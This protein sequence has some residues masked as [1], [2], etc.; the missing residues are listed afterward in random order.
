MAIAINGS[1]NTIT[2]LAVG[3]LPDGVVDT[4]MLAANAVTA[5]KASGSVKGITMAQ[6]WRITTIFASSSTYISQNWEVQDQAGAGSI[7]L[8]GSGMSQSSG[9]F[10][11]PA[12][13]IYLIKFNLGYYVSNTSIRYAG[14]HIETT[15]DN[16]NYILSAVNYG[17]IHSSSGAAH[18]TIPMQTIFNVSDTS[19]HKCKFYSAVVASTNVYADSAQ[20]RTNAIFIRLG[21]T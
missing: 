20:N 11:F 3:G 16:S 13:G 8:N 9:V 5:A 15:Q 2:G 17:N 21:D 6:Q 19:T 14:G 4:D 12:T 18:T 10:T 7:L 1:S